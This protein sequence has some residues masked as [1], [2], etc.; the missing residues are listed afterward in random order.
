MLRSGSGAGFGSGS[1]SPRRPLMAP[2][3]GAVY[4][5]DRLGCCLDLDAGTLLFYLNG[6]RHGPGH[7]GVV[8][9]VQRCVEV[10]AEGDAVALC[11][12]VTFDLAE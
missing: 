12:D 7:S 2:A 8:G 9:P 4:Q 6:K 3:P 1:G 11:N 10:A 5:G